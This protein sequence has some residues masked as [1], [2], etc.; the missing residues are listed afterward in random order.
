M[1]GLAV[2]LSALAITYGVIPFARGWLAREEIIASELERLAR[3]RGLVAN[4]AEL[5]ELLSARTTGLQAEPQRLL[6][7]RTPALAAS[8]LQ[9]L[10]QDFADQSQ[11]MVSR[12][13]VAGAPDA[14]EGALPAIPATVS[15][16]GDIYGVTDLL[17]LIQHGPLLLE[18]TEL[19]VRPNP[20]L[21]GELLQLTVTV[22]AAYVAR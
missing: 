2:S 21:R 16:V 22:H 20:A 3:T 17:S 1:L 12:L 18:I 13:D 6:A 15:A 11:V 14:A 8:A 19:S 10:L 5:H 7:G 9:S 4:E